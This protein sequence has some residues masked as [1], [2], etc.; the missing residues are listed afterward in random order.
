MSADHTRVAQGGQLLGDA[1]RSWLRFALERRGVADEWI[2]PVTAVV[3]TWLP[4]FE[5]AV[6]DETSWGP[7]KQIAT[8]LQARGVDPRDK[9]ADEVIGQNPTAR[10][11]MRRVRR[12][13]MDVAVGVQRY[14][15]AVP[16]RQG[17]ALVSP[18]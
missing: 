18:D 1:L 14:G 5:R 2:A 8:E 15:P 9:D 7:A 6:D 10:R 12:A 17:K 3:G 16:D 11:A 13:A 4:R